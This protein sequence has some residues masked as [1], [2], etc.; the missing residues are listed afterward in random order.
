M[1]PISYE[2]SR[3]MYTVFVTEPSE[4]R[5]VRASFVV[6]SSFVWSNRSFWIDSS[7][8]PI[9]FI[10]KSEHSLIDHN[11]IRTAT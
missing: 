1:K 7:V 5:S 3:I 11:V 2:N 6:G 10:V 4:S 9:V 8:Q